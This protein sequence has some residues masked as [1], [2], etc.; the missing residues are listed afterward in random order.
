M[1]KQVIPEV[2]KTYNSFDDGKINETRRYSVTIT[3]IIP[4]C[5]A[6]EK[7]LAR[8]REE[9]ESCEWLYAKETDF[10]VYA[11]SEELGQEKQEVF[12]RTI[13]GGW[14]GI[15]EFFG[16]SHLDVDGSLYQRYLDYIKDI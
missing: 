12:A 11:D 13:N 4:F 16:S 8:W 5:E 6:D 1:N 2:G 15:G 14:F 7:T 9:V 3:D 10:F